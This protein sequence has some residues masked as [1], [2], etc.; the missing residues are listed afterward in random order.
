MAFCLITVSVLGGILIWQNSRYCFITKMRLMWLAGSWFGIIRK[1]WPNRQILI[2]AKI[3]THMVLYLP[4]WQ[5]SDDIMNKLAGS[6]KYLLKISPYSFSL[7]C[8]SA[9]TSTGTIVKWSL[10]LWDITQVTNTVKLLNNAYFGTSQFW[11]NFTVI[12]RLSSLGGKNSIAM[13][14]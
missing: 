2:L 9:P 7:S 12:Q 5:K 14:L 8:F 3:S 6:I 1:K 4:Q 10:L 11:H 13:V